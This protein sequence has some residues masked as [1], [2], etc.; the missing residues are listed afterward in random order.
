MPGSNVKPT[1]TTINYRA[2][3]TECFGA[4]PDDVIVHIK[5]AS[6][7][8]AWLAALFR[9]IENEAEK[10]D[11]SSNHIKTLA[12][13]GSYVSEDFCNIYGCAHEDFTEKLELSGVIPSE[14]ARTKDATV[15]ASR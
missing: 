14:A 11:P 2:A 3:I 5:G 9:A 1:T 6:D 15:P 13:L 7:T 4:M 12:E 10:P 8:H